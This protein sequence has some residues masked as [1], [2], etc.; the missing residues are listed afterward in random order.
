M[1]LFDILSLRVF[2]I[3]DLFPFQMLEPCLLGS[4]DARRLGCRGP[5]SA[6]GYP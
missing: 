5:L 4:E 2:V 3:K 1:A 6:V